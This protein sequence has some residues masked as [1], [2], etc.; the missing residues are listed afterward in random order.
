MF[1]L[2]FFEAVYVVYRFLPD[3]EEAI[4][5]LEFEWLVYLLEFPAV[6]EEDRIVV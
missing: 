6:M 2:G 4:S 3:I 1:F 5:L